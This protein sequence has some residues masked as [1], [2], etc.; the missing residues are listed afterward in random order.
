MPNW[1]WPLLALAAAPAAGRALR[2]ALL[3]RLRRSLTPERV[4]LPCALPP[5]QGILQPCR[6]ATVGG[7][8]LAGWHS[9]PSRP[10]AP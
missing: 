10:G 3:N 1:L 2:A 4:R 9:P 5:A 6:I 8:S 7:L